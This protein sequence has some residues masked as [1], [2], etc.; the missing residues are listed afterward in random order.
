MAVLSLEKDFIDTHFWYRARS[1]LIVHYLMRWRAEPV[2]EIGAGSGVV[3]VALRAAGFNIAGV[4][5]ADY[6]NTLDPSIRYGQDAFLIPP[7]ERQLY[8]A[9][10]LFDVLEHISDRVYFFAATAQLFCKS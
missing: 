7:E 5:I 8:K 3:L 1:R 4:D 6:P 10:A 2:L 9:L